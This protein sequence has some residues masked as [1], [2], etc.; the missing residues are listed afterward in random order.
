MTTAKLTEPIEKILLK[1][2]PTGTLQ[3]NADDGETDS[4]EA[5]AL[6]LTGERIPLGGGLALEVDL[7]G[8]RT[9][10][11]DRPGR[12]PLLHNHSSE[13]G[14]V[15]GVVTSVEMGG[16][17]SRKK[18]R[19]SAKVRFNESSVQILADIRA[20]DYPS[21][22]SLGFAPDDYS[23]TLDEDTDELVIL[24]STADMLELSVAPV[25]AV[26]VAG[27]ANESIA[28]WLDQPHLRGIINDKRAALAAK[29]TE[30]NDMASETVQK[31]DA[32][33]APQNELAGLADGFVRLHAGNDEKV[34]AIKAAAGEAMLLEEDKTSFLARM[35]TVLQGGQHQR[36]I[37]NQAADRQMVFNPGRY[38]AALAWPGMQEAQDIGAFEL[39]VM[40]NRETQ[41]AITA[42]AHVIPAELFFADADIPANAMRRLELAAG[43]TSAGYE[44][45]VPTRTRVP[46][47]ASLIARTP[48]LGR[49]NTIPGLV[50]DQDLP[51]LTSNVAAHYTTDGGDPTEGTPN[52]DRIQLQ[53]RQLSVQY[54]LTNLLNIQT[55]GESERAVRMN[56]MNAIASTMENSVINGNDTPASAKIHGVL[57]QEAGNIG[58]GINQLNTVDLNTGNTTTNQNLTLDVVR[59]VLAELF[60]DFTPYTGDLAFLLDHK[61]FTQGMATRIDDGSGRFLI[62]GFMPPPNGVGIIEGMIRPYNVF[63]CLSRHV[64]AAATN[65]ADP[66]GRTIAVAGQW[67]DVVLGIWDGVEVILDPYT[68]PGNLKTTIIMYHDVEVARASSFCRVT[69]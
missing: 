9:G 2:P 65:A 18:K 20:G 14:N 68:A 52:M 29:T 24:V 58:T 41:K 16:G 22:V 19:M 49:V 46:W 28:Q 53:P 17:H 64:N 67:M 56:A 51:R 30:V 32:E 10:R 13:R 25:P 61:R 45:A 54:R 23:V 3:L 7:D 57:N 42:G 38:M 63:A 33:I 21:G 1:M 43:V 35:K 66:A 60:N 4:R 8:M 5:T 59:D 34:A 27:F 40:G 36:K 15:L 69:I 11:L 47:I 62:E 37:E 39:S 26:G 55:S 50:D 6:V 44:D 12:V 48:I 31:T